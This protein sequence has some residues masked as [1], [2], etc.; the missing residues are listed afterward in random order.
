MW[1]THSCVPRS[2][3]VPG[4][5]YT[6]RTGNIVN[7]FWAKCFMPW[8]EHGVTEERFRFIEEFQTEDWSMAELCRCYGVSRATGYKW[9]ERYQAGGLE[10]LGDRSRAP[11]HTPH[12]ISSEMEDLVI[13]QRG[14]H[15]HWGAPKIRARLLRDH[16]GQAIPAES[17]IGEILKRNGLTVAQKRRRPGA[18]PGQPLRAADAAN[19]VWSVDFKGWF[20]T[21]DGTRIDPLTLSDNYSRYLL[22]CQALKAPTGFYVQPVC[23]AAFREYGLPD[24]MRSDNGAPFGS[25]GESG[26]TRLTVWWIQLGIRPEHIEPGQPQQNGRHE[27]MHRTLKQETAAPSA[28]NRREQ[29][30]RF[31]QFRQQYNQERPHEALGQQTPAAHYLPSRRRYPERLPKIEYPSAWQVRQVSAGGQMRWQ[32]ENVF[33][34]HALEGQPVGLEPDPEGGWRV[35]FSFYQVGMLDEKALR[36]RRR[37]RC[38]KAAASGQVGD[39]DLR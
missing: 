33:V 27:R 9:V 14:Q 30:Q 10:A 20:R 6:E 37:G 1:R 19:A 17:T 22:R 18:A 28:R 31:D 7:T 4:T 24:G 35:W 5:W 23:E 29:Q 34:A 21:G 26:L 16:P 39:D 3:Y 11:R 25:N 36:I 32:G 15:P 8:K 13:G 12:A 38:Q 2:R